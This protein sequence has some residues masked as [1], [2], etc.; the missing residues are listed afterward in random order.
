MN[1]FQKLRYCL[2]L[3]LD[4]FFAIMASGTLGQAPSAEAWAQWLRGLCREASRKDSLSDFVFRADSA[5]KRHFSGRN[6]AFLPLSS[7]QHTLYRENNLRHTKYLLQECLQQCYLKGNFGR[8]LNIPQK[9][10]SFKNSI[11]L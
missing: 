9:K 7:L 2:R 11:Y 4:L 6:N 3:L 1:F 8:N 5:T 10:S